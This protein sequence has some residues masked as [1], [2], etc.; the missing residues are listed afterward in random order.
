MEQLRNEREYEVDIGVER[1]SRALEKKHGIV[2]DNRK[3]V[4]I[5]WTMKSIIWLAA[6]DKNHF[7]NR[8]K[9]D[10][11]DKTTARLYPSWSYE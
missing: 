8:K 9:K 2:S 1:I 3:L 6:L 10:R 7:H 11:L 4:V 5:L